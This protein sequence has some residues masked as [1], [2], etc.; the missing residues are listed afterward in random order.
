MIMIICIHKKNAL[1]IMATNKQ[2]SPN[3]RIPAENNHIIKIIT[4]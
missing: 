1:Q 2:H 3:L 4:L